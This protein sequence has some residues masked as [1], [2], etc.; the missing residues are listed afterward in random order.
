MNLNTISLPTKARPKTLIFRHLEKTNT[1]AGPWSQYF[2]SHL[3][4]LLQRILLLLLL[5]MYQNTKRTNA[6]TLT[7]INQY[8]LVLNPEAL[9]RLLSLTMGVSYG[10]SSFI[11]CPS[12]CLPKHW[13]FPL[14]KAHSSFHLTPHSPNRSTEMRNA[15]PGFPKLYFIYITVQ[16]WPKHLG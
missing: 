8:T 3:S 2:L 1:A 12:H 4:G 14:I 16:L 10:Y 5:L 13:A 11:S 6:S 9:A 15:S 7:S